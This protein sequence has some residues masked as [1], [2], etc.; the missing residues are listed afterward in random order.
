AA[1]RTEYRLQLSPAWYSVSTGT[2]WLYRLAMAATVAPAA[3]VATGPEHT[4]ATH[5]RRL[6]RG[7]Q[8]NPEAAT[9]QQQASAE[10]AG[11][12]QPHSGFHCSPA[13][14]RTHGR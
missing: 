2:G 14:C 7:F 12:H 1:A 13:G 6:G 9:T 11:H 3:L 4:A 10:T 8:R 5:R